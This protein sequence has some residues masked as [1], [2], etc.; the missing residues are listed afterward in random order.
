MTK[1][2]LHLALSFLLYSPFIQTASAYSDPILETAK[3]IE[4]RLNARV[5]YAIYDTGSNKEWLYNAHE[6]F[7]MASTFKV[8]LCATVLAKKDAGDKTLTT[9]VILEHK[10]FVTYSPVTEHWAG[11]EVGV[12][13]LCQATMQTSD[14]TAANK[15]LEIIG[16][17]DS[18]TAFMHSIGDNTT[19][20]DRWETDLNTATPG[21]PRDT[22]TPSAMASSLRELIFGE[23]LSSFSREQLITWLVSNEVGGPLLRAGIPP[24]WRIGDRTGAGGHGSRGIVAVMWPP[25]RPPL[26]AAIYITQTKASM[27]QRNEAIAALGRTIADV[28]LEA[29]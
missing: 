27:E 16:G 5:G 8:L 4:E 2:T 12:E 15:A 25:A 11:K 28:V 14:N 23:T 3:Q 20:L 1:L 18:V 7:P 17:P 10:D 24:D 13:A 9:S 6:R 26:V 19:R 29:K 22:T 21:D